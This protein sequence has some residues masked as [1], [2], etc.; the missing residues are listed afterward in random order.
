[1]P[2]RR[3]GGERSREYA[4]IGGAAKGRLLNAKA[5]TLADRVQGAAVADNSLVEALGT[6]LKRARSASA[7]NIKSGTA[8][9]ERELIR[10][11]VADR[12][13]DPCEPESTSPTKKKTRLEGAEVLGTARRGAK[14][15]VD[16][17]AA[18][19]ASKNAGT[20]P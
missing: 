9:A 12:A 1:M 11:I 6:A 3:L 14:V 17:R 15:T 8:A 10:K 13:P 19:T 20:R 5:R 16:V 2:P 18:Y 7:S 4:R